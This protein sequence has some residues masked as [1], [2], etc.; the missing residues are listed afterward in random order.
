ML[1]LLFTKTEEDD[2]ENRP[3]YTDIIGYDRRKSVIGLAPLRTQRMGKG[4]TIAGMVIAVLLLILFLLD[5]I[6]GFPFKKAS[7]TADIVFIVCAI[8]LGF[9]SWST[10]KDFD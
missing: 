7:I 10:M 4:M 8:G 6:T 1:L 3:I 2:I 5:L 9:L